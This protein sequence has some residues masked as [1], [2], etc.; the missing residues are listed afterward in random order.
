MRFGVLCSERWHPE[1]ALIKTPS[2]PCSSQGIV[3]AG[4]PRQNGTET[5]CGSTDTLLK[6]ARMMLKSW[7][8]LLEPPLP[9][10]PPVL[11]GHSSGDW[12]V[13]NS[14]RRVCPHQAPPAEGSGERHLPSHHSEHEEG[15]KTARGAP[16]SQ[17]HPSQETRGEKGSDTGKRSSGQFGPTAKGIELSSALN[18]NKMKSVEQL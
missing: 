6:A 4:L 7:A 5:R 2:S 12:L 9:R 11:G 13:G 16:V 8:V 14:P 10:Q 15:S 3:W 1:C 18:Q 17:L